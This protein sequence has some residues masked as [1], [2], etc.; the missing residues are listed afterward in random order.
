MKQTFEIPGRLPGQ[1][2]YDKANRSSPYIGA[3]LKRDTQDLIGWAIKGSKI[4]PMHGEVNIHVTYI[5]PNTRRDKDNIHCSI[6]FIL[7]ALVEQKILVD[8][9]WTYIGT[10]SYSYKVNKSNPRVIVELEN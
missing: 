8:D 5:E 10:L 7:D 2:E 1:N 3:K 6:K 9:S 4:E